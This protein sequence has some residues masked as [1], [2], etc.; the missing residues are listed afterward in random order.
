ME[1]Q[2]EIDRARFISKYQEM[3]RFVRELDGSVV[4][5]VGAENWPFPIPLVSHDDPCAVGR[6][7]GGR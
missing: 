6:F 1:P 7:D 3:H 5:Y 4:L 2:D